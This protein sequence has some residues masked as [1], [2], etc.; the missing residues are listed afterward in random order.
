MMPSSATN[1]GL[2]TDSGFPKY[3][4]SIM[5]RDIHR[6]NVDIRGF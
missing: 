1:T 6:G 4:G 2:V 5:P 3:L